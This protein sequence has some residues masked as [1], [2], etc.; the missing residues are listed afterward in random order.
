VDEAGVNVLQELARILRWWG[1]LSLLG[2]G[3]APLAY[4]LFGRSLRA[5]LA[6]SRFLGLLTGG[7]AVWWAA[8]VLGLPF[9]RAICLASILL[10]AALGWLAC[11]REDRREFLA[12]VR[13]RP[14]HVLTFEGL[15]LLALGAMA[16]VRM[17]NPNIV[18][19]E[20]IADFAFL[21]GILSSRTFPPQDPWLAGAS[22]NYFYFGHYLIAYLT[23][24]TGVLPEVGFNLGIA[25][26]FALLLLNAYGA[27]RLLGSH[28]TG[29]RAGLFVAV[30]GNLDAAV[31]VIERLASSRRFLPLNWFNWWRSSRVIVRQGVDVT[32]NEFPFWSMIL[33]DLHAHV[34]A[35]PLGALLVALLVVLARGFTG[36]A[37]DSRPAAD[38][39][40]STRLALGGALGL[41]LGALS[42]ANTW[43]IP[44]YLLLTGLT[45]A[46]LLLAA[47]RRGAPRTRE[48]RRLVVVLL[49]AG[50]TALVLF[51]PFH[52]AFTPAGARGI[53][54]VPQAKRTPLG[55]FLTVHGFFL[56]ILLPAT[57]LRAG[58][59]RGR[60]VLLGAGALA[61]ASGLLAQGLLGT[62][63]P[64]LAL[65][66]VLLSAL[67]L[68]NSLGQGETGPAMAA[69][70][71]GLGGALLLFCEF[72]YIRDAYGGPLIRQ[73]TI[74]KFYY[75]A[76]VLF[77]IAA[78]LMVEDLFRAFNRRR[79]GI[80]GHLA[81]RLALF[82]ALLFTVFGTSAKCGGFAILR[83]PR[84][85]DRIT[86][87]GLR[88]LQHSRPEDMEIIRWIRAHAAPDAVILET[89]GRPFSLYGRF[90]A[91]TG[92]PT[93]LGW[94][95]HE[96]IWRN[97]AQARIGERRNDVRK[98]YLGTG[99]ERKRLLKKYAISYVLVGRLEREDY[100]SLD[101]RRWRSLAE[102]IRLPAG[103][104]VLRVARE[105]SDS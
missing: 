5:G 79:F 25:S 43:D 83:N 11:G 49:C 61:V 6:L 95:N 75:Q 72:L 37:S 30:V 45:G 35:A 12:A 23:R 44:T 57:A 104:V 41:G 94:G 21:N 74:F 90:S 46:L 62:L 9:T 97:P 14:R 96:S 65:W 27:G 16:V 82:A 52:R 31:Q 17:F 48:L 10:V 64:W 53:G 26:T 32:I 66:L 54:V 76:W 28:D 7:A 42:A 93:V 59:G 40:L 3:I 73:N 1:I 100:P 20:K 69:L 63:S 87:D 70:L 102:E 13:A 33:G 78:A 15:F 34:L 47:P 77:G 89:T 55:L 38:Q 101:L 84:L 60:L 71:A 24:L 29:L 4:R 8:S 51:A 91:A 36:G 2:W 80:A 105:R 68:W 92:R 98:L 67:A 81:Y 56:A 58:R 50:L 99:P 22:I 18:D 88:F 19:T 85:H 103:G 86:L 39:R